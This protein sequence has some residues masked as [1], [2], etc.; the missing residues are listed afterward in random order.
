VKRQIYKSFA[1][2]L[3]CLGFPLFSV[4]QDIHYSN[5]G[6]SPLNMNPALTGVFNGEY[7]GTANYRNQWS[8]VPVNY[9]TFSGSVDMKMA[10]K[11]TIPP[12]RIGAFLS[13][14]KAGWS[15]LSNTAL[16]LS[17]SY[18]QP[19]SNKDFVSGGLSVGLNQR[20]FK[21]GDLT[22]DDQYAEKRFD[23]TIVSQ[24]A[25]TFEQ[26]I[27][28]PD[29]SAGL[30]YHRQAPQN[31]SAFD[32]GFGMFHINNPTRSFKDGEPA[33]RCAPRY[34][35]YASTNLKLSEF[36]DILLDGSAQY[37]GPHQELVGSVGGRLY[38]V[39]KHTKLIA[40]QAGITMRKGD[41]ISPHIGLLYNRWKFAVNFDSNYSRFK[42]ASESIGGPELNVIYI[43]AKVRPANYC[44]LCPTYL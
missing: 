27:F 20:S 13:Y 6:F 36:F 44:A 35:L 32:V 5:F 22:W 19:L 16:Y 28:Y 33:V 43:F 9:T 2:A 11:K 1:L 38:L 18:M 7:R 34:S 39:E 15:K 41:A 10:S 23:P 12:F 17:G 14:D 37:Q 3:V 21:T 29:L 25:N 26:T 42:T 4:A 40:L 31:R 30:N 24:D 8:G